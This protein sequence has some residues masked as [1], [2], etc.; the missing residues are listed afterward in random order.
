MI[1]VNFRGKAI[2]TRVNPLNSWGDRITTESFEVRVM[3]AAE[4]YAMIRRRG[5]IPFVCKMKELEEM[6]K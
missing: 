2:L 3:A 4:G 5:A 1:D 6:G